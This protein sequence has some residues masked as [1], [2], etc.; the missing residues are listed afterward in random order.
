[1]LYADDSVSLLCASPVPNGGIFCCIP[2]RRL[3]R[4]YVFAGEIAV[5][6]F[7]FLFLGFVYFETRG[8]LGDIYFYPIIILANPI[9]RQ[10]DIPIGGELL[11][12][13]I[14][15]EILVLAKELSLLRGN[16]RQADW[17]AVVPVYAWS[18][19]CGR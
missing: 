13:P 14:L 18:D 3:E 10:R 9:N 2:I 12:T 16:R 7:S 6:E 17:G 15:L 19:P 5:M 1:M 4:G 8:Y 11:N